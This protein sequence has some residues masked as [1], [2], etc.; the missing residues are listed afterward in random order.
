MATPSL[1]SSE[2][3]HKLEEQL[4]CPICLEQYTN[5][6]FLP[7]FHSFCSKCLESVP[8]ELQQGS[9]T[10]PCPTCRS[11][12]QL[13]QQGIQ[14][15]PSSF[16][17]N[18]LTSEVYNLMKKVSGNRH[19]SCDNCNSSDAD[20]YCKQCAKFLCQPCL[21]QHDKW[22]TDHQTLGLDTVYQLPQ[23]KPEATTNC[24]DHGKLLEIFCETC[25]ELICQLCTVK[26]HKDHD[27]DVVG[28]AFAKHKCNIE[29]S[30]RLLTQHIDQLTKVITSLVKRKDEIED[31]GREVKREVHQTVVQIKELLDQTEH[32]LNIEVDKA[33]ALKL[34]LLEHQAK[35]VTT[36]LSQL[37]EYRDHIQQSLEVDTPQQILTAKSQMTD[38]MESFL[39]SSDE[40]K[41]IQPLE[42][43]DLNFVKIVQKNCPIPLVLVG[44]VRYSTSINANVSYDNPPLPLVGEATTI[45]VSLSFTDGT[46]FPELTSLI[47]CQLT[48]LTNPLDPIQC[49]VN[50]TSTIGTYSITFTPTTRGAHQLQVKVQGIGITISN[51]VCIPVSIPAK[52]RK[53]V[54]KTIDGLNKPLGIA[55]SDDGSVIISEEGGK[56]ITI[57]DKHG[58]RLNSF[59]SN[60]EQYSAEHSMGSECHLAITAKGTLLF[61]CISAYVIMEFSMTGQSIAHVGSKAYRYDG[62]LQFYGPSGIAINKTTGQVYITECI[63]S[64]VQVLNAD[65]TFSHMFGSRGSEQGEL[66]NPRGIAI[67]SQGLVYVVDNGNSRIQQFT[68]EGKHLS[69][70]GTEGSAPGQ[71]ID[72][73]NITVDDNDLLYVCEYSCRVSVFTTTGK[74]VNCFAQKTNSGFLSCAFDK[75]TGALYVCDMDSTNMDIF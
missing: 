28:D 74:I 53:E 48:P 5:P 42:Q 10:L 14:A 7:C 58:V 6:K 4:T 41:I 56:Y 54:V 15:L 18:N 73:H 2:V 66:C 68:P 47:S 36:V 21:A 64:R 43:A 67:D 61:T 19:V 50:E 1:S 24:A 71:L 26:K 13:P 40:E 65:L 44:T 23:A 16:T 45:N 46:P 31:Q 35:K 29:L 34:H 75:N 57:L 30:V 33:L 60:I 63:N 11:P 69:S 38:R 72:P 70:F 9:Y 25:E 51:D 32:K 12:C 49:T 52:M 22:I 37:T 55:V 59:K 62:P 39:T 27:Y 3:L 20:R 8:L 17:I